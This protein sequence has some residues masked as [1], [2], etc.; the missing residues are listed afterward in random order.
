MP[1]L[2]VRNRLIPQLLAA[3]TVRVTLTGGEPTIHPD[4]LN[5]VDAFT[6]AG[7]DVTICTNGLSHED[8]TVQRLARSGRVQVNV[9][10]DGFRPESHGK[11]RG[12]IE[13]F[14]RTLEGIEVF[15]RAGLLKGLLVTPNDLAKPIEYV[16]LHEFASKVGATFVLMNPL[17]RFGRGERTEKLRASEATMQQIAAL[18]ESFRD[19]LDVVP[20]RFPND[21]KDLDGCEAGRIFYVFTNGDAAVC[22]YLVFAA[23]N[24]SSKHRPDEFMACNAFRDDLAA[25]L[26]SY[27]YAKRL[28]MGRNETCGACS[29]EGCGKGCPAAVVAAGGRVGDLDAEVCPVA[30]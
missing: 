1:L 20:I 6:D 9:S 27:D 3:N 28:A 23:K 25:R 24:K 2:L 8:E 11:F 29:R 30:P 13:S 12:D 22:P 10:L 26:E 14:P 18:A 21:S 5:L 19:R 4:F 17:S 7:L 15:A 16:E